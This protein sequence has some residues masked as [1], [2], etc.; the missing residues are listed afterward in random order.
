LSLK[1]TR[2]VTSPLVTSFSRAPKLRTM[3][4]AETACSARSRSALIATASGIHRGRAAGSIRNIMRKTMRN[5]GAIEP[6][7]LTPKPLQL[8]L[9]QAA[10]RAAERKGQIAAL[11]EPVHL[12]FGLDIQRHAPVVAL[13]YQ[14]DE[15]PHRIVVAGQ[16]GQG[17]VA[18]L[19]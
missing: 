9:P 8:H 19:H 17:A 18:G 1:I 7:H 4:V 3:A 10:Q 11:V 14:G 12:H 2:C 5:S 6:M 15:A 13:V 16:G